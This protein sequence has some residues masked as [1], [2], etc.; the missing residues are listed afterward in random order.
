VMFQ[1][2]VT[3]SGL[4][5]AAAAAT[6]A[7]TATTA[8][9]AA[10][11]TSWMNLQQRRLYRR[12]GK[13]HRVPKWSRISPE[14]RWVDRQERLASLE[15]KQREVDL[16]KEWGIS[17]H[18]RK[19]L[20]DLTSEDVALI[21]QFEHDHADL[22]RNASFSHF[23]KRPP[24]KW[25]QPNTISLNASRSH[26]GAPSLPLSEWEW[27]WGDQH[28]QLSKRQNND[29]GCFWKLSLEL[30]SETFEVFF[31]LL[32]SSSF[33]FF[34]LLSSFFFFFNAL[35]V[36]SFCLFVLQ[37]PFFLPVKRFSCRWNKTNC[38]IRL[39]QSTWTLG[40]TN[41]TFTIPNPG[42]ILWIT[43]RWIIRRYHAR[44]W[45][46]RINHLLTSS[47][48]TSHWWNGSWIV[49]FLIDQRKIQIPTNCIASMTGQKPVNAFLS[50][51]PSSK[52]FI[53][54]KMHQW[55]CVY[56]PNSLNITNEQ[57][58]FRIVV[59]EMREGLW[60]V[61]ITTWHIAPIVVV[62]LEC[63]RNVLFHTTHWFA[64]SI[65]KFNAEHSEKF[66]HFRWIFGIE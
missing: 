64:G 44:R 41:S 63:P 35:F 56:I 50:K 18:W 45:W 66:Y 34:L 12:Q 25:N 8:T 52:F 33:F 39:F 53:Y 5:S 16:I 4:S 10:A 55:I 1:T 37:K 19:Y 29:M 59:S 2:C 43:H 60:C 15:G 48:W 7:A 20:S 65:N 27:E 36:R 47:F 13:H 11:T 57:R 9:T 26:P 62:L 40:S 14:R 54:C 28:L 32:L 30:T 49:F 31:F 6:T 22:I 51:I 38:S 3:R 61:S 17:E 23:P 46:W 42:L 21:R 58:M 24:A